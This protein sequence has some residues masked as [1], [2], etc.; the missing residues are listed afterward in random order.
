MT[1]Y[2]IWDLVSSWVSNVI[3]VAGFIAVFV[4]ISM[5][6]RESKNSHD[7]EC[8]QATM[9]YVATQFSHVRELRES[10]R[11]LLQKNADPQANLDA[12]LK[13]DQDRPSLQGDASPFVPS[14]GGR[15]RSYLTYLEFLATGVRHGPLDKEL[16]L[17][18]SGRHCAHVKEKL[19]TYIEHARQRSPHAASYSNFL[20]L[21]EE[22]AKRK[23]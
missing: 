16:V 3:A 23:Q 10:L 15:V 11:D 22:Q 14:L 9:E 12:I 8:K 19:G 7:R 1:K 5:A 18:M 2:E 4:Q 17:E 20:W 6:R 13:S 21:V